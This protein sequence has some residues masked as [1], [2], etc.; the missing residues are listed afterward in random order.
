MSSSF[1]KLHYLLRCFND[2]LM[3]NKKSQ[4][5]DLTMTI[6]AAHQ[7]II[8]RNKF[9]TFDEIYN[10]DS[11][12]FHNTIC[13]QKFEPDD[14]F[15]YGIHESTFS[16]FFF[17][18]FG[19][20]EINY[21]DNFTIIESDLE[22]EQFYKFLAF[23]QML[24]FLN[25]FQKIQMKTSSDFWF[26]ADRLNI[27]E[28]V[29]LGFHIAHWWLNWKALNLDGQFMLSTYKQAPELAEDDRLAD[30]NDYMRKVFRKVS[31]IIKSGYFDA[32]FNELFTEYCTFKGIEKGELRTF[33]SGLFSDDPDADTYLTVALDRTQFFGG[34]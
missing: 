24:Q 31:D 12:S 29:G 21:F 22:C 4:R 14:F 16:L 9:T 5:I 17:K 1:P 19:M 11:V 34:E 10:P 13:S 2:V 6:R 25:S 27:T 33:L 20:R 7:S 18:C 8:F 15:T 28:N 23:I 26:F 30:T 3:V 32:Y